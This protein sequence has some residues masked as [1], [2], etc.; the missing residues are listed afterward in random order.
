MKNKSIKCFLQLIFYELFLLKNNYIS[1]LIDTLII[2]FTNAIVFGYF[3]PQMATFKNFGTFIIIGLI[4]IFG[5]FQVVNNVTDFISD[6]TGDRV[7]TYK[8][9]LPLPSFFVF[10]SVSLGW[11]ISSALTNILIFPLGKLF[12]FE[13]MDL[14]HFNVFQFIII[15]ITG[16]I[17]YGY[18]GLWIA[19]L[20]KNMRRTSIVW[21]RIVNPLFMLG[22]FFYTWKTIY[23]TFPIVGIID[24]LNPVIYVMEGLRGSVMGD[25]MF[26]PYWICFSVL[27]VAIFLFGYDANRRLKK[28]LDCI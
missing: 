4:S 21:F 6:L 26:I 18:F 9:L 10:S 5:L 19:S 12:L 13:K 11:S 27:W 22:A 24:L 28:R 8:L 15:F 7:I 14:S 25:E 16:Y 20:I 3:F 17:F 1:R 23:K 2:T